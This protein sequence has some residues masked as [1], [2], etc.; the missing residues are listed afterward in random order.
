MTAEV[1]KAARAA[2]DRRPDLRSRRR[3]RTTE[4]IRR[5]AI[6]LVRAHGLANV[7]VEMIAEAAGISL[8]SF[9]NYFQY[10]EE[11]LLPP[12]VGF[13]PQAAAAFVAGEGRLLDDLLALIEAHLE[14]VQPD[15]A[16]IAMIMRLAEESPRLVAVRERIFAQYESEF[17]GLV[18]RRLGVGE[19][20]RKPSLI[21][22]V[23]GAA[24]RLAVQRW[25]CAEESELGEEV[26]NTLA[27]LP[28]LLEEEGA[29]RAAR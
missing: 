12:P 13:P 27:E 24:F 3:R 22:A 21:A 7:T 5:A 19:T 14:D 25:I 2:A 26:R 4:S 11:A 1:G 10:K 16:E 9:F 28:G 20:E 17:R 23:I 15:R 8:R 18:A 6:A 29:H